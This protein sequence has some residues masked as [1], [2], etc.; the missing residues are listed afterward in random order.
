MKTV[1]FS[2][3]AL[4]GFFILTVNFNALTTYLFAGTSLAGHLNHH[5]PIWISVH[6]LSFLLL[7]ASMLLVCTQQSAFPFLLSWELMT[8]SSFL[9]VIFDHTSR[10]NLKTG[11]NYLVQMHLSMFLLLMAFLVS[12]EKGSYGFDSLPA[13]FATHREFPLFL[14]FFAGFGIKA[15]MIPFHTWLPDAH[16]SAPSHVSGFMSGVMI[17]MGIYGIFRVISAVQHDFLTIGIF[18]LVISLATGIYGVLQAIVQH[19]LKK[20]LAYHSIEN[21]GIIGTGIGLGSI[22]LATH[23]KDL[24]LLGFAGGLLHVLNHS[25]FKSLLFFAAG[26]VCNATRTRIIDRM[27]G[28]AK[29]MPFTAFFFLLGSLSICGLPPFNGFISEYLLYLGMILNIHQAGFYGSIGLIMAILGLT[30]IGGL[31]VFCFTKAFGIAFLGTARSDA[32][33]LAVEPPPP[34]FTGLML[35]T[36]MIIA[37]GFAPVV[38]VKPLLSAVNATFIPVAPAT[39]TP[40]LQNLGMISLSGGI[41]VLLVVGIFLLRRLFSAPRTK[42]VAPTWACGFHAPS[43]RMQYTATSYADNVAGL[44]GALVSLNKEMKQISPGEIFPEPANF[45]SHPVEK[46]EEWLVNRPFTALRRLLRRIA[47]L[48]TGQIRHYIL[49]P[50]LFLLLIFFLTLLNLL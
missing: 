4:S 10:T 27:G 33:K 17:K 8:L 36:A 46:L 2:I 22:G 15:G 42:S 47:F 44:S 25:L 13:F 23:N 39:L 24:A 21:I 12:G 11:I 29:K 40:L 45:T 30:L 3:D 26:N 31:A 5:R 1:V 43:A 7:H 41:F 32:C 34:S 6:Y 35:I 37:I 49:Y 16:P 48:Q 20:L 19:D 14:L 9:L 28:L 38:F 50:F 18:V